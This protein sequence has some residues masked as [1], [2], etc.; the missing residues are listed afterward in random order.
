MSEDC[1]KGTCISGGGGGGGG[2]SMSDGGGMGSSLG[3]GGGSV[4]T[5]IASN[6]AKE[7]CGGGGATRSLY[8]A[9]EYADILP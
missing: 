1:T 2:I 5:P 3:G 6:C 9:P 8:G 4:G 7:N